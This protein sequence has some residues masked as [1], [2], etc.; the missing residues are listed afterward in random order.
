MI[1][2][3]AHHEADHVIV[4]EADEFGPEYVIVFDG[5]QGRE[6]T[7]A[8]DEVELDTAEGR[9]V[10]YVHHTAPEGRV[11]V[12]SGSIGHHAGDDLGEVS[13][14]L[15]EFGD[16]PTGASTGYRGV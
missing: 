10:F 16:V 7:I 3:L 14:W 5:P 11:A 2:V 13:E 12:H 4:G 8:F 15:F 6:T 9:F 1:N